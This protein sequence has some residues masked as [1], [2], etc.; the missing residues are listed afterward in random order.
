MVPPSFF[1]LPVVPADPSSGLTERQLATLAA[2]HLAGARKNGVQA[3]A[4]A[5]GLS[6][7][8]VLAWFRAVDA[9]PPAARCS[10]A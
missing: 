7:E 5:T 4:T 1:D 8:R 10:R 9:A 3:T 2:A 6:R